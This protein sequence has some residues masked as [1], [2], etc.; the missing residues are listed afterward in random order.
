MLGF[1]NYESG[2]LSE[3]KLLPDFT[4]IAYHLQHLKKLGTWRC[5]YLVSMWGDGACE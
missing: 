4:D 2:R 1:E 5:V 3:E